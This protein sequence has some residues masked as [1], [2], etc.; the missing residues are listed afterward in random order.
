MLSHRH[1]LAVFFI[2]V[3]LFTFSFFL[4]DAFAQY[5][6]GDLTL[7]PISSQVK[8]GDT[9]TFS[10]QLL[11]TEGFAYEGATIYIK[12]DVTFDTD[13]ILGTVVT[14][15]NGEFT[16]TWETQPRSGGGAYDFYAVFE[17]RATHEHQVERA[18]AAS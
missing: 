16:A 11:T 6:Y 10:G 5:Y 1:I 3:S 4:T 8:T 18:D 14:D 2:V 17:G 7:N 13:T 15:E 12:D 9:I